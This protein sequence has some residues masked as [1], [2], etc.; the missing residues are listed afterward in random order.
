[1]SSLCT[2]PGHVNSV[3][4][5]YVSYLAL[6]TASRLCYPNCALP[7]SP[8]STTSPCLQPWLQRADGRDGRGQVDHHR[9]GGH[10]AGRQGR[11]GGD[12]RRRAAVRGRR[13]LF[14]LTSAAAAVVNPVLEREGLEGDDPSLLL[15]SRELRR[16][17]RTVARVNGRAVAL[18]VLKEVGDLLVDIHGQTDHLSLMR[19][20]EHVNL[21]DRYAGL[22]AAARQAGSRGAPL[23]GRAQGA[24]QPAPRPARAGPPAGSAHLPGRGDR[25][26][27][28]GS[29]A[30]TQP[31]RAN[32][33]AWPTPSSCSA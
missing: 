31:W 11:P 20:R 23:A 9:R 16:G 26:R 18:A 15:L 12:P 14:I 33:A 28:A 5:R 32:A 8:S 1:M 2:L 7:T 21:L 22:L 30:R 3:P 10:A 19:Q 24:G 4:T 17:G 25:R 6:N 29:Q 13:R 27:C